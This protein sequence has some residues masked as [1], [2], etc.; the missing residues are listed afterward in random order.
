M[1]GCENA[2]ETDEDSDDEE[3]GGVTVMVTH[4]EEGRKNLI[5][6]LHAQNEAIFKALSTVRRTNLRGTI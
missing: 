5:E 3:N 4:L 1:T 2:N 6:F